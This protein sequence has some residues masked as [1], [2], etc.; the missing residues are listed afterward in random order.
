MHNQV[1]ADRM[2]NT[3]EIFFPA[4]MS[5]EQVM[6]FI[7]SL[8]GLPKAKFMQPIYAVRFERYVDEKG[9][10][11]FLHTPGRI[12][13]RLDELFYEHVDGSMEKVDDEDDPIATMKWQAATEL[14]MPGMSLLRQRPAPHQGN[15]QPGYQAQS[16]RPA[17]APVVSA[18]RSTAS[19][20]GNAGGPTIINYSGEQLSGRN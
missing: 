4:S 6:A 20:R 7:R 11:F 8:S 9:E 10:R 5:H 17:Q 18:L 19:N 16:P 12:A 2:R 15:L 1:R 13:A 3:F 14:T